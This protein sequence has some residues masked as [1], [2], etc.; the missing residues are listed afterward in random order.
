M[1]DL[2]FGNALVS[3]GLMTAD[4]LR[5]T[6]WERDRLQRQGQTLPQLWEFL[7]QKGFLSQGQVDDMLANMQ[8][9]VRF[10]EGCSVVVPVPRVTPEGERCS[11][12]G[13]PLS[14][15]NHNEVSGENMS[16]ETITLLTKDM[17][18]EVKVA[19]GDPSRVL[20]KYVLVEEVGRGGAGVVFKAWDTVLGQYVALKLIRKVKEGTRI[21]RED[22]IK[23]LL[24]EARNAV[25]L[26]HPHIVP[27]FD[28][29]RFGEEFFISMDYIEGDSLLAHN[30]AAHERR[31]AS[32]LYEDPPLYLGIMRDVAGAI[33][34]AHTFPKPIVHCD[35]K[36]GNILLNTQGHSYLVDFGLAQPADVP[37]A[38]LKGKGQ[39]RGTPAYM[40]P[41]QLTGRTEDIGPWT[42]IYAFGAILFELMAG[43]QVFQGSAHEIVMKAMNQT[44]PPPLELMLKLDE[45]KR[46]EMAK[47]LLQAPKLDMLVSQCLS[48]APEKRPQS[49]GLIADEMDPIIAALKPKPAAAATPPPEVPAAPTPE[50]KEQITSFN[51]E[52]AFKE[53]GEPPQAYNPQDATALAEDG[54]L[55]AKCVEE[56]KDRMIERINAARPKVAKLQLLDRTVTNVELLRA[57]RKM[58]VVFERGRSIEV[59][60][61]ALRP[62]GLVG[63]AADVLKMTDPPDRLA[64]GVY[65]VN[66]QL[67]EIARQFFASLRGTPYAG[68]A[69]ALM[70]RL[71]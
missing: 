59:I 16:Q 17:P 44:A 36:P 19:R 71:V 70:N 66:A 22:L 9:R 67:K 53:I 56:F 57:T 6:L 51:L 62:A 28:A 52:E 30:R 41:E 55:Q 25:R 37:E 49:A 2:E 26:R 33:H 12:C 23:D 14:L 47:L 13:G 20:G 60:W 18:S 61:A 68:A 48:K 43:R 3:R 34:Y 40:A 64:L 27:I 63:L 31:R 38:A 46:P 58:L 7:V 42:D 65:C 4:E 69:D 54:R 10:C 8:K 21:N 32:V 35:L 5:E 45:V 24:K 1:D 29:G 39:V 15:R 11:R 50:L